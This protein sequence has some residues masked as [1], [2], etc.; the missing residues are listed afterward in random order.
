MVGRHGARPKPES[1]GPLPRLNDFLVGTPCYLASLI[2]VL[3]TV[4]CIHAFLIHFVLFA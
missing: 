4:C 2:D 3:F 1:A